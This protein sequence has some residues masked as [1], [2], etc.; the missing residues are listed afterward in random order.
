MSRLFDDIF[1]AE[2]EATKVRT[3][4]QESTVDGKGKRPELAA[5]LLEET[6]A[7]VLPPVRML[8]REVLSGFKVSPTFSA[9]AEK[10]VVGEGEGDVKMAEQE[11]AS[12]VVFAP[13]QAGELS[14]VFGE[15]LLLCEFCS[16]PSLR[17]ARR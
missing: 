2:E 16:L 3:V 13:S 17:R 14:K 1:G 4:K 8:W 7:H 15:R 9:A 6:P 5:S 10:M 11:E 12:D